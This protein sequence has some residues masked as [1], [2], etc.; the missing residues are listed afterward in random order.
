MS[1]PRSN[2]KEEPPLTQLQTADI[3]DIFD[4]ITLNCFDT[5]VKDPK[6][7]AKEETK[8][9]IPKKLE[10]PYK[11]KKNKGKGKK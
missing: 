11:S 2:I 5:Y 6:E 8:S 1:D 10:H 9:T 4:C 7:K 3:N